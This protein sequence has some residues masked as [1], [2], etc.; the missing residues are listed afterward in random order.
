MGFVIGALTDVSLAIFSFIEPGS[1]AEQW[2]WCILSC[3]ILGFGVMLE[4]RANVLVAPGEGVVVAFVTRFKIPFPR[5][6]VISDSTMVASAV[7]MSI[8]FTGGLN[9]VR[10]GTIFA[11]VVLG[12]IVG[13]YRNR[14]GDR[15]DRL[16]E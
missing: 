2:F 14:F 12:F 3:V 7:V 16:L 11:A 6:K 9:G 10:E 8:L 15:I 4:V 1:Y 5:M 13:F